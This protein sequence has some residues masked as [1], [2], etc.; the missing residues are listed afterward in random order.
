MT[1]KIVDE[2]A[3]IGQNV[4]MATI[5]KKEEMQAEV[6]VSSVSSSTC[7]VAT[8]LWKLGIDCCFCRRMDTQT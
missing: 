7:Y 4:E 8:L 5:Q 2:H 1:G 6:C 3:K